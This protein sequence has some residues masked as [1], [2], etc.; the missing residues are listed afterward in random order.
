MDRREFL[1]ALGVASVAG[2]AGCLG[3]SE[4]EPAERVE[5]YFE[6]ITDNDVDAVNEL[7]HEDAMSEYSEED[8]A[9]IGEVQIIEIEERPIEEI[10]PELDHYDDPEQIVEFEE[11]ERERL[12]DEFELSEFSYVYFQVMPG[13]G[14]VEEEYFLVVR[15]DGKWYIWI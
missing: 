4:D 3:S 7:I 14:P 8:I 11:H 1:S 5:A 13:S 9:S 2:V 12:R 6:A 15:D 10:V